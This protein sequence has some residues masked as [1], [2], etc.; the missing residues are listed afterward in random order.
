MSLLQ[1]NRSD[2]T[3]R[4]QKPKTKIQIETMFAAWDNYLSFKKITESDLILEL[5]KDENR[6]KKY[7][8]L[9]Q[10]IQYWFTTGKNGR[11]D[12]STIK[13]Y[14][15]FLKGW[16]KYNEIELDNDKIKQNVRFP[17]KVRDRVR[18]IDRDIIRSFLKLCEEPFRGF[19]FVLIYT[20][21]RDNSEG[22]NMEWS[23]I[24]F[25]TSPLTITLPGAYTKT[26]Q[27]RIT[28]AGGEAE[29]WLI[30]NRRDGGRVFSF[31]YD[32]MYKYFRR[33]RGHMKLT[34]KGSS[35]FY[36]FRPH[37][38]RGYCENKLAKA[39]NPEFAHSIMGHTD[40]LIEYNQ[41]GTTDD[42]T[43]RDYIKAIPE[44]YIGLDENEKNNGIRT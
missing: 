33:I 16:L 22:I 35:N 18:G 23:W 11:R 6:V 29:E 42:E 24:D 19:F 38:F 30:K 32:T 39:V 40:G 34:E 12:P 8:M 21:V 44:L 36:H 9:D 17:K 15:N 1:V 27:E 31:S 28:F 43:R 26:G 4:Y 5:R 13:N 20:G 14:F 10:L 41:G 37:K 2:F 25:N 7:I 3:Q